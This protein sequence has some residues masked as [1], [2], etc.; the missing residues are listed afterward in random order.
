MLEV[1]EVEAVEVEADAMH[2]GDATAAAHARIA[3][4]PEGSTEKHEMCAC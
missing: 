1:A 2:E 4:M 3:P